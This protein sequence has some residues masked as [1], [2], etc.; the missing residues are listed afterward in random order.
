MN[1]LEKKK[2][3]RENNK[4]WRELVETILAGRG[5]IILDD[6]QS[7]IES[8]DFRFSHTPPLAY[9]AMTG[10]YYNKYNDTFQNKDGTLVFRSHKPG[11]V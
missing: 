11:E 8:I 3:R 9:T 7:L 1:L 6:D 10:I 4:I 5:W 2:K